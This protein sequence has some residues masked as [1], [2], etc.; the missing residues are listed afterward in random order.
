MNSQERPVQ[1]SCLDER[2]SEPVFAVMIRSST[3]SKRRR[4]FQ[5]EE[6]AR[7]KVWRHAHGLA[8]WE[9]EG[10]F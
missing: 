7:T 6:R 10:V 2:T 8:P 9:L 4:V 1:K 3:G 5:V